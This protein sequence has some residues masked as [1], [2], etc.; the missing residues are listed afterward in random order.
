MPSREH[1]SVADVRMCVGSRRMLDVMDVQ[2]QRDFNMSMK[3]WCIYYENVERDRLLNVISL[4]F[5]H[6]KLEQYV[7]SPQIVKHVDW[8][9]WVDIYNNFNIVFQFLI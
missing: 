2:T 5:S 8:I 1:F 4:E 3:D 9:D 7:D 6:T